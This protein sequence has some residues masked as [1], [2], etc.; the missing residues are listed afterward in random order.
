MLSARRA[1]RESCVDH[2]RVSC[3][4]LTRGNQNVEVC[5][6]CLYLVSI[7][8]VSVDVTADVAAIRCNPPTSTALSWCAGQPLS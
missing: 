8:P 2:G 4:L 3:P 5:L 1:I 6:S 7:A